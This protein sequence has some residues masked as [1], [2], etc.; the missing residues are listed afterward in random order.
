MYEQDWLTRTRLLVGNNKLDLLKNS[1]VL[2]AG[3]GGVGAYAAEQICRAGVGK[4]TIIDCDEVQPSNRN[5]QLPA[6]VSTEGMNKTKVVA[7]RLLDINPA[8]QL[9]V[10]DQYLRHQGIIEILEQ[11]FD[12]V[13]DAIDTLGPKVYLIYECVQ[14]KINLVSSMGAGGKFDPLQVRI[15]DVSKSYNCRLAFYLRKKLRKMGVTS[16]F[17]VVYSAEDVNSDTI[18]P[19]PDDPN[20]K[21]IVGTISYMPA[22]FGCYCASVAIR[23]IMELNQDM[24]LRNTGNAEEAIK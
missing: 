1:H 8:L 12:Y 11:G 5:R 18:I 7:D 9:N 3:L 21:S 24:A 14:R 2:I 13:I 4:M 20:K 23:G 17:Q 16:G 6:L 15:S 19:T 22:I 10:I